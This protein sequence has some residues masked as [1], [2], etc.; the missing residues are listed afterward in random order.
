MEDG[1]IRAIGTHTELYS[2]DDLYRRLVEALRIAADQPSP[3]LA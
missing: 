3:S 2:S 1:R